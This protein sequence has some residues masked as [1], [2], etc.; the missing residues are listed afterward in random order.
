MNSQTL[1]LLQPP[2]NISTPPPKKKKKTTSTSVTSLTELQ[3]GHHLT[4]RHRLQQIQGLPSGEKTPIAVSI[5][6]I[7]KAAFDNFDGIYP[8]GN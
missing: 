3:V 1:V 8:P 4:L 6:M 7:D 5:A 2:F